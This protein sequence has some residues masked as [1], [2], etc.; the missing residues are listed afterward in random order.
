[1]KHR[2]KKR[3]IDIGQKEQEDTCGNGVE[4]KQDLTHQ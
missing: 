3:V 2:A 1:M 4:F